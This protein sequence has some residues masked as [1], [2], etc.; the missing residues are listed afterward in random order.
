MPNHV[1]HKILFDVA[2]AAEIT[3]AIC[4]DKGCIDFEKLVP[5]PPHMYHGNLSAADD[6]D[7]KCNWNTWSRANW[8]TKWNAYSGATGVENGMAFLKFETAWSIPYPVLAAFCNRFNV[9][10]EHRYFDEGSNYWGI[11]RWSM[12]KHGGERVT[13]TEKLWKRQEDYKPLCIELQGR[14]PDEDEDVA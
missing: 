2:R 7:F 6:E 9:P 4:D 8:G 10:F 5:S 1:T 3:A 13:R 12:E 14:N 11:E